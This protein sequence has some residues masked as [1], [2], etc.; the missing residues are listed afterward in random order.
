MNAFIA[1]AMHLMDRLSYSHKMALVSVIFI[2]PL[3]LVMSLL[4][5]DV[6]GQKATT[7]REQ[8]GLE[9]VQALKPLLQHLPEHR[10]L[11][12][13]FLEGVKEFQPK[14][15]GK[16]ASINADIQA[17]DKLNSRLAVPLR[18]DAKWQEIKNSW[19]Q[20]AGSHTQLKS[21]GSLVA[22]SKLIESVIALI[23]L[24]ADNSALMLDPD[25]DSFYLMDA[26]VTKLPITLERLGLLRAKATGLVSSRWVTQ[27]DKQATQILSGQI[28]SGSQRTQQSLDAITRAN[29]SLKGSLTPLLTGLNDNAQSFLHLADKNIVSIEGMTEINATG[30][31]MFAAGSKAV[32]AGF[33]LFDGAAVELNALLTQRASRLGNKLTLV[34]GACLGALALALY[35]FIGFYNSVVRAIGRLQWGAEQLS[36]GNLAMTVRCSSQDELGQVA[37]AFN[38]I[39]ANLREMIGSINQSTTQLAGASTQLRD[40]TGQA[41]DGA[42]QQRGQTEQI[43]HVMNEM[44]SA[45]RDVA[46]STQEAEQAANQAKDDADNGQQVVG[47]AIDTIDRLAAEVEKASG[48]IK[49][50]ETD[51]DKIGSVV[52]VIRGIAEQTNLLALN[53]AIEAARAGEQGRGFAVVADEVRTLASRTQQ[54]TEEIQNMIQRLQTGIGEAVKVMEESQ[55]GTQ[56]SVEQAAKAGESL[57]AIGS[58]VHTITDMNAQIA[59]ASEEQSVVAEDINTNL[60]SIREVADSAATGAQQSAQSSQELASVAGELQQ[61]VGRFQL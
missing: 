7:E 61:L 52:D 27:E 26:I 9:Y 55:R 30:P 17:I 22:H 53:A 36:S 19:S 1:P 2:L 37:Q 13:G 50:L 8:M 47:Q 51:S 28:Q 41:L 49:E 60:S 20:L 48:V 18:L 43:A 35:L 57:T 11:S 10:G 46:H 42:E 54:S 44:S 3:I 25:L 6:S 21:E 14:F 45:V 29:P 23:Q 32:D 16:Q 56:D 15:V 59:S 31:E 58:A 5:S 38:A 33:A 40:S 4:I 34:A 12:V 24:A 39:T